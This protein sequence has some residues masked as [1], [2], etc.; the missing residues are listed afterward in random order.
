MNTQNELDDLGT[1]LARMGQMSEVIDVESSALTILG[2]YQ[3]F[4]SR[5]S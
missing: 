2:D 3:L 4:R 1:M 5:W